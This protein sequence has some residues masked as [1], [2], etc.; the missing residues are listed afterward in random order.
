MNNLNFHPLE[1]VSSCRDPQHQVSK[2]YSY[3]N[4]RQKQNA[5]FKLH[6]LISIP[7]TLPANQ[8]NNN[9]HSRE[10]GL[11]GLNVMMYNEVSVIRC[12]YIIR[13]DDYLFLSPNLLNVVVQVI[14]QGRCRSNDPTPP[15]NYQLL[16]AQDQ[17]NNMECICLYLIHCYVY[18]LIDL[19]KRQSQHIFAL[20]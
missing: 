10:Q 20:I 11:K 1:V 13:I 16:T 7:L 15:L 18:V 6:T 4:F 14:Y 19:A 9:E 2:N 5:N 8:T 17:Q 12:L 3:L